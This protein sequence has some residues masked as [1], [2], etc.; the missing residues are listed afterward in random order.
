MLWETALLRGLLWLNVNYV[1]RNAAGQVVLGQTRKAICQELTINPVAQGM[2]MQYTD[3]RN[4]APLTLEA[5][6]PGWDD[7]LDFGESVNEMA[8][9]LIEEDA[10]REQMPSTAS[11]TP[12]PADVAQITPIPPDRTVMVPAV[13]FPGGQLAGSSRD[14]PVHLSDATDASA[15]GSHPTKDADT[16]DE[17]AILG[18]FSDALR[19]MANSIVGLE[20]GYFKAQREVIIKTEK[21]L[22][23]MSRIDAHYVS[24]VVTVMSSWQEAVQT[25]ASHMEG[26]DMTTY[27]CTSRGHTEGN[28]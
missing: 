2:K 7:Y 24:H 14:N 10:Q 20:D 9:R 11:A 1:E 28:P 5:C 8:Q 18:H 6:H 13:E 25:A 27:L 12:K 21:A 23:D 26:V 3:P 4:P 15:S 19:E 16:E 22:R 17:A